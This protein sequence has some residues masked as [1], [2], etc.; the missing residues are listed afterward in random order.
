MC[1]STLPRR[2]SHERLAAALTSNGPATRWVDEFLKLGNSLGVDT[3]SLEKSWNEERERPG[4]EELVDEL[5]ASR[6]VPLATYRLPAQRPVFPCPERP[7][8][9]TIWTSWA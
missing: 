4:V 1:I 6:Y 8:S 3:V 7:R 5:I 9:S 2:A